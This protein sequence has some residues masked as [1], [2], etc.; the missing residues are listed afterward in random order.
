MFW[1]LNNTLDKPVR[2]TPQD[3]VHRLPVDCLNTLAAR[4][5]LELVNISTQLHSSSLP[6]SCSQAL[7][8]P[9]EWLSRHIVHHDVGFRFHAVE[10]RAGPDDAVSIETDD[11]VGS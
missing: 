10:G 7:P 1:L 6:L 2:T 9:I 8:D 4:E 3:N 5:S 11:L